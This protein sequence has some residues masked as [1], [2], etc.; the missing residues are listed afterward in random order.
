[1]NYYELTL[2]NILD[3]TYRRGGANRFLAS[4]VPFIKDHI[5]N[6][7]L[8]S[9]V[10]EEFTDFLKR[11][12]AM[13]TGARTLPLCFV[14]GVADG[15]NDILREAAQRQGFRVTRIVKSPM[16]GL[17]C[18]HSNNNPGNVDN[19]SASREG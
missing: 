8:Y 16:D 13:Y 5:W 9:I 2:E 19:S 3:Y 11:N 18:Y 12:V 1:M 15:F 10:L 14:G 6:P 4:L 17:I 7:Y